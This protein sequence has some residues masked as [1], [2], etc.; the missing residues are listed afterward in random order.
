VLGGGIFLGACVDAD[1]D[2]LNQSP[3]ATG[4]DTNIGTRVFG[5]C[6][7]N[8]DE[9]GVVLPKFVAGQVNAAI[10][11]TTSLPCILNAWIDWNNDGDFGEADEHVFNN[12]AL[13]GGV[14]NLLLN[15][16]M[17]AAPSMLT[18]SRFRCSTV[19]DLPPTGQAPDG[20]VEDHTS[21]VLAP[22]DTPTPTPTNTPTDTP[23]PTPT[24]TPT[25]TP[26]PTPTDTPTPT[27][28]PTP[29]PTPRPTNTVPPIPV[30]PTPMSPAG[31][32]MILGLG[33]GLL[34]S[35]RRIGK[36]HP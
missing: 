31:I 6:T 32:L 34:W 4:D 24:N 19:G 14:N 2:C 8:D 16:P 22:T 29:T 28:T 35:L 13:V 11:V 1:P 9:D 21:M 15:V 36:L 33:A 25:N 30:V 18:F 3:D 26:T 12:V 10:P 23:T 17:T 7:G 27:N 20:E 5:T